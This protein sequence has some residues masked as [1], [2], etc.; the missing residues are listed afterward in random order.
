MATKAA[1]V[2]NAD[3]IELLSKIALKA[4]NQ[5]RTTIATLAEMKNPKRAMFVKQ[6]NQANQMQVNNEDSESKI[7]E[8]N[9][10]P[11]NEQLEQTHGERLDTRTKK[12][13]IG[14][15]QNLETVEEVNRS[16]DL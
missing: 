5:C 16:K 12:E 4:Q 13:A 11:A 15:N 6:L 2:T 8:K 14:T 1:G 9:I 10:K 7:L 3:H